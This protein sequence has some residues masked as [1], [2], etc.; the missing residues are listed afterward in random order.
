MSLDFNGILI[1][2]GCMTRDLFGILQFS[3]IHEEKNGLGLLLL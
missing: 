3:S 2:T 1:P